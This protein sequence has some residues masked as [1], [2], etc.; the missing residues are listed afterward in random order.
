MEKV[1]EQNGFILINKRVGVTSRSVDNVIQRLFH[2]RK[3]GHLGT[4]D[5]FASGLLVIAVNK[6]CKSLP[7]LDDSFKTYQATLSLGKSTS[8]GD[9]TGEVKEE[10]EVPVSNESTIQTIFDSFLGESE[11]IPPM[12]SALHH[13]GKR[14]YD[15]SRKGIEIERKPRKIFIKSLKLIS[16]K[17]NLIEF[18]VVCSRGTYVR[19][20]GEDIAL[21]LGTV[22]HLTTLN[23][24]AIGNKINLSMAKDIDQITVENLINPASLIELPS[25][26]VEDD[27]LINDIKA[28]KRITLKCENDQ[29]LLYTKSKANYDII[30]L[31]VYSRNDGDEYIIVRGLW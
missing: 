18:E 9:L 17:E 11:Q 19:T 22:G 14:L 5:P 6:G 3:V 26:L 10:K 13:E 16:Y 25:I 23:R 7:F 24:I 4:L 27:D 8:T 15:L 1:T 28:G 29:I 12:T 30:A 21:K 20:L 2:T 31:A